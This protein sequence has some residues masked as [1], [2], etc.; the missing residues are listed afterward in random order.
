[1]D[2]DGLS[3]SAVDVTATVSSRIELVEGFI[4]ERIRERMGLRSVR[5]TERRE[6]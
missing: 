1:M 3:P 5:E 6:Y 2:I 4:S